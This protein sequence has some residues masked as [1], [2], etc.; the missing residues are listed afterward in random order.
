MG[1]FFLQKSKLLLTGNTA[2]LLLDTG[3][4]TSELTQVVQLGAAHLTYLVHLDRVDVGR[5]NGEDTLYTHGTR[6]LANG[7]TLLLTMAVDLDH[8]ATIEL[9]ALFGTLDNLVSNGNSVTS[10]ELNPFLLFRN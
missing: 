7:E 1:L 2:A 5:L 10:L 4:L 9:D 3:S 8:N 6:H